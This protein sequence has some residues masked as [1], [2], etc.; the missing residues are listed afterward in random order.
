M[1]CGN[2]PTDSYEI[3]DSISAVSPMYNLLLEWEK[4]DLKRDKIP[5]ED[6]K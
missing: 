2:A 1:S 4:E 6:R 3:M 5:K